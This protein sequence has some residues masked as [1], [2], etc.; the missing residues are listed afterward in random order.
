MMKSYSVNVTV[1]A[2]RSTEMTSLNQLRRVCA[3]KTG[4]V[5]PKLTQTDRVSPTYDRICSPTSSTDLRAASV[6]PAE[7]RASHTGEVAR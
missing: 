4:N 6:T 1:G 5:M 3:D 2:K 7:R